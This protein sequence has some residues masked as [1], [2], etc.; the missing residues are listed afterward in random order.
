MGEPINLVAQTP[1]YRIHDIERLEEFPI[2][3]PHAQQ[4]E[5]LDD[6]A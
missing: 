2:T 4:P 6:V 5:I 3:G 1:K